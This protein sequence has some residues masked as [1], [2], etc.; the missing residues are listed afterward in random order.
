MAALDESRKMLQPVDDVGGEHAAEEQDFSDQKGPH[1]QPAGIPLLFELDSALKAK[2]HRYLGDA[3][4]V[5]R[6]AEAVA[7]QA[8]AK[9]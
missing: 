3:E 7:N 2:D 5:R 4:Q 1:A 6:A 8:K 9:K